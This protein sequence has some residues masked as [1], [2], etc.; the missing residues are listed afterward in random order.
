MVNR[1]IVRFRGSAPTKEISARLHAVPSINVLEE[2]SR[3]MLVEA[4]ESDLVELVEPGPQVVIV[5]ERRIEHP[6][7]WPSL[8]RSRSKG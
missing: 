3:M 5:P 1:F 4:D 8:R 7:P 6:R 2:T